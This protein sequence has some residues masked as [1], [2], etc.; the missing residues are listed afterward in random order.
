M[1]WEPQ[2][3]QEYFHF[4]N[5]NM[6]LEEWFQLGQGDQNVEPLTPHPQKFT[7]SLPMMLHNELSH[8]FSQSM[9]FVEIS[10]NDV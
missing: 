2:T 5:G 3:E 9:N 7:K 1:E 10:V 4:I 6:I 8:H